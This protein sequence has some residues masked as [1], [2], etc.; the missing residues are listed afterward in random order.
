[1]RLKVCLTAGE[2]GGFLP[3]NYQYPLSA[4]I[5]KILARADEA[6]ASFLH[7]IG[8]READNLKTFKLFT[9]SELRTPFLI[10]SD[11]LIMKSTDAFFIVCFHMPEA[12]SNFVEGLFADQKIEIGDRKSRVS[13]HVS[14]TESLALWRDSVKPDEMKSA[15]FRILSPIAAGEKNE[16][17]YYDFFYP[18][19]GRY[20][21]ALLLHW[22]E[23]HAA[24]YG[25]DS[26]EEDFNK[27]ELSLLH[28]EKAKSRLVT[29]KAGT[30]EETKIR[31]MTGFGLKVKAKKKVLELAL[32]A[33]LGL[34]C[35][36][37]FGCL[38]M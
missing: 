22:K 16:R 12:A 37:G 13:F 38:G 9:F 18:D 19:H 4:V 11:R 27:M 7:E 15:E 33:G 34:Y 5:Y 29:I 21:S 32:N 17:G 23:K 2:A 10:E 24:V 31:G 25:R 30:K 20:L 3:I 35:S 28:G 26:L 8:Y 36:Q 14:N 6:Y 1:M